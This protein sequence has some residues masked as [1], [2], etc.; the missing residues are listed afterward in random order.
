MGGVIRLKLASL[1][2]SLLHTFEKYLNFVHIKINFKLAIA[3][4]QNTNGDL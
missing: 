4:W 1:L 2:S 3:S